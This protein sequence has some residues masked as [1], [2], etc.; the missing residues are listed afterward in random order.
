M[1]CDLCGVELEEPYKSYKCDGCEGRGNDERRDQSM[2]GSTHSQGCTRDER[3][4]GEV[5]KSN[6]LCKHC[7]QVEPKSLI[8]WPQFATSLWFK[9]WS[10][11]CG[12]CER[13]FTTFKWF[14][15]KLKC[16]Y[17]EAVNVPQIIWYP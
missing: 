11:Q 17:C 9:R 5:V 12:H 6:T 3:G 14:S 8:K 15:A 4:A 16:P 10:I 13:E 7:S 1:R 2:A